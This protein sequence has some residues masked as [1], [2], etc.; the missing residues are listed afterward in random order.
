[1]LTRSP[2]LRRPSLRLASSKWASGVWRA[3]PGV[4]ARRFPPIPS[5][6]VPPA[7]L[8]A[9]AAVDG[10][11][12]AGLS[13]CCGALARLERAWPG[14]VSS[15]CSEGVNH[16]LHTLRALPATHLQLPADAAL[17]MVLGVE[18][19]VLPPPSFAQSSSPH[20]DA[21]AHASFFFSRHRRG[22][23]APSVTLP[24]PVCHS[25]TALCHSSMAAH[26]SPSWPCLL[27][28]CLSVRVSVQGSSPL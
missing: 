12:D 24:L 8:W 27:C 17:L 21:A 20:R 2:R 1:V 28:L 11:D 4:C 10:H 6:D 5:I 9:L 19:E 15:H 18:L 14:A 13:A 16:R 3:W 7:V 23:A 22:C 25:V 26:T